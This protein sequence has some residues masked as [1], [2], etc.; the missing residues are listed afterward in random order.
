M[1][2]NIKKTSSPIKKQAKDPNRHLTTE[3]IQKQAHEKM[4]NIT[5]KQRNANQNYNEVSFYAVQNGY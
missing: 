3:D 5:N 4:L 2:L 1:Q